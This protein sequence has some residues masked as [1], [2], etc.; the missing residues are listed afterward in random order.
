MLWWDGGQVWASPTS[1]LL[2]GLL[3][4]TKLRVDPSDDNQIFLIAQL[5]YSVLIRSVFRSLGQRG[6]QCH[7]SF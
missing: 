2:I 1:Y 7:W 3:W 6:N 4:V 5:K